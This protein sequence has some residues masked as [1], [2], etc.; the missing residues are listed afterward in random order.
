MKLGQLLVKR[1]LI[2][3]EQRDALLQRQR[4]TGK[5]L[6]ELL[7]ESGVVSRRAVVEALLV[8][9]HASVDRVTLRRV[10]VSVVRAIPRD[11]AEELCCVAIAREEDV[12]FVAMSDP[13]D[14]EAAARL[15]EASGLEIWPVAAHAKDIEATIQAK[16][17]T[18]ADR[19][20]S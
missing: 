13:L 15:G 6:G 19:A 14:T 7:V 18:A 4:E 10:E 9:P 11:L 8:Q 20:A 16:Y 12:L 2:T 1:R 5:P 17:E 3:Q